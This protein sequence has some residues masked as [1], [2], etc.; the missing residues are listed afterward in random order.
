MTLL[1]W[2]A[3]GLAV[4]AD[5]SVRMRG[6]A[7]EDLEIIQFI[8]QE[9]SAGWKDNEVEPSPVADDAEWIR[10][11]S[12]DLRGHIPSLEEVE[13][14]VADKEKTKRTRVIE[15]FLED[16]AYVRNFTTIWTNLSI[17][18][19]TPRF[20]H[21]DGMQKFYREA[22]SRNRPWKQV[23]IDLITAEGRTDEVG[24]TNYIA[25]QMQDQ[26]DGVQLTAKTARL[27]LG[28]QVQCTQ[29]HNHPFNDWKQE[30]FWQYNSFFRQTAKADRR[31][32]NPKTN[33]QEDAY[34]E[35]SWKDFQGPVYFEKRNG[36]MQ[37]AY[38]IYQG[39]EV[40]PGPET[41]R[42]KE[43]ARLITGGDHPMIARAFVNRLWCH[44]FGN[45]FTRPIDD[46]APHNP[47][48]HPALLDR[49]S[50]EF[51]KCDYDIKRLITWVANCD[52][53]GLTS[54]ATKKNEK[55]NP[56]AGEAPLFTHLAVK[57]MTAEQLYD[58]LIVATNAHKA[59]RAG[60]EQ[61]EKQRQVWLNQFIQAFGNDEGEE[62]TSFD[63]TIPQA[64]M[65]MNG[66][67]V[68]D[69]IN[70]KPGSHLH[71]ILTGKGDD[72]QKVNR[73]YLS[74][75]GRLPSKPETAKL[76]ALAKNSK[77]PATLYQDLFWALLN[78]NEFI[79]NH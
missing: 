41:E 7:P 48:T 52:A 29:C 14:F 61:S 42:R 53:Y 47:P 8:N 70:V 66:E 16:P 56:A 40:D 71:E 67:L 18:Q 9:L 54:R 34:A 22:F 38:P 39:Q 37:V 51:V 58:S 23:V 5:D 68:R 50:D 45:G 2:M 69:A 78:S 3:G 25:A 11:V 44:F 6:L 55:D 62:S 74:T 17:G 36:V 12:L 72:R 15:Q 60:W 46:I 10:R 65:M 21:R 31:I 30:Q 20:V 64:L 27:F 63:G 28:M 19:Q 24:A 13:K 32:F 43:L 49:L 76:Q 59:G 75:L 33:R 4:A 1:A 73:L 77:D 35:V 26:D 79:F 57:P